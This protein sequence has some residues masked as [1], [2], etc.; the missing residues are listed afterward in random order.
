[1]Q[2]AGRL[3]FGLIAGAGH[4]RRGHDSG[5]TTDRAA[6]PDASACSDA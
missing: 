3:G 4:N 6:E 1:M 2:Q 5:P